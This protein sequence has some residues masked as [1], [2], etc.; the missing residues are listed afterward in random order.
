MANFYQFHAKPSTRHRAS[1]SDLFGFYRGAKQWVRSFSTQT[2][3]NFGRMA[4]HL[5][6]RA[7]GRTPGNQIF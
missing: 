3:G 1:E 7:Y 2:A 5:D 6:I 4:K